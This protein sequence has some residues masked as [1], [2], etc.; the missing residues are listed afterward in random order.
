MDS[1][2]VL[3]TEISVTTVDDIAYFLIENTAKTVAV[4]NANT[5]VRA[6]RNLE[7]EQL[8]DSFDVKT[9]DGFPV[10]KSLKILMKNDQKRVD[11]YNIFHKTINYGLE[12]NVS[13]YFFG[14]N[15][16]VVQS[17][18]NKLNNLLFIAFYSMD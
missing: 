2:R 8:V 17:M 14:N 13:H 1:K 12:K 4:C 5:L 10:A 6:Y 16:H 7:I 3:K 15:E 18:I 11:G 9:P